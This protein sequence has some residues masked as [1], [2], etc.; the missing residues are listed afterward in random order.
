MEELYLT[1]AKLHNRPAAEIKA[2]M[3]AAIQ[4]GHESCDPTVRENWS[5]IP[6]ATD[7]PTLD[8]VIAFCADEVRRRMS[9]KS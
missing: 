2:E 8:E 7:T 9:I 5:K 4:A 3:A 1:L 6:S